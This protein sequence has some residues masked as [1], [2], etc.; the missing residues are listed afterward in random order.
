M[1]MYWS[2]ERFQSDKSLGRGMRDDLP[3]FQDH[4]AT[5]TE[6]QIK[7][8]GN[9]K[10][11]ERAKNHGVTDGLAYC[12]W[13]TLTCVIDPPITVHRKLPVCCVCHET[14]YTN[15]IFMCHETNYTNAISMN[16]HQSGIVQYHRLDEEHIARRKLTRHGRIN[17]WL[18]GY[19]GNSTFNSADIK[20]HVWRLGFSLTGYPLR[21]RCMW[22]LCQSQDRC[23][24]RSKILIG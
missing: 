16:P 11:K 17:L 12:T 9:P 7:I 1:E 19:E 20:R 15:A 10:E 21:A 14:N 4:R 3:R 2:W 5:Q 24:I 23:L 8:Q 22:W 18:D 6:I 13:F